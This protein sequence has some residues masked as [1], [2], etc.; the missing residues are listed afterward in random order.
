MGRR[1]KPPRKGE[2]IKGKWAVDVDRRA[3]EP[4][5]SRGNSRQVDTA[6]G[7][8]K[9]FMPLLAIVTG[10]FD[11]AAS[12]SDDAY[13]GQAKALFLADATLAYDK[14]YGSEFDCYS[15]HYL[16]IEGDRIWV[17]FNEQSGRFEMIAASPGGIIRFQFIDFSNESDLE[18]NVTVLA[19]E[20][21]RLLGE[22]VQVID[23]SEEGCYFGD[24]T[25]AEME[26]RTGYA[27]WMQIQEGSSRTARLEVFS[28]CCPPEG[29]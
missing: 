27:A 12:G 16:P 1:E 13:I 3:S 29:S 2:R 7:T 5:A 26:D 11:E 20:D 4:E 21:G 28:F 24:E 25:E 23:A 6:S 8:R 18:A 19:A 15:H 10:D 9:P 22:T 17:I 14:E